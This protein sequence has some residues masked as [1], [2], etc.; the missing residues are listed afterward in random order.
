MEWNWIGGSRPFRHLDGLDFLGFRT[1]ELPNLDKPYEHQNDQDKIGASPGGFC[2]TFPDFD[3]NKK[4]K[5][6]LFFDF[7]QECHCQFLRYF[8]FF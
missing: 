7:P 1:I 2:E 8:R 3:A 4:I 6:K 5:K